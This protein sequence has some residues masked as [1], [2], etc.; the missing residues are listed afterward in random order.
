MAVVEVLGPPF[1]NYV[2]SVRM[3][4]EEKGVAYQL[5]EVFP[6]TP[7]ID[8]IHPLGKIPCLKHGEFGICESAAIAAYIDGAFPGPKLFPEEPKAAAIC[9]QWVSI[10]NTTIIPACQTYLAAYYFPRTEDGEPNKDVVVA[11]FP[12]ALE[13]L[14]LLDRVVGVTG[15]LAGDKFTYAD[16]DILPVIYYLSTLP[17]TGE[18]MKAL[19]ALSAY[20]GTHAKRAS[21][22]ATQPPSFAEF[23]ARMKARL[24]AQA[25]AA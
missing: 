14:Q 20:L 23:R 8:A 11:A 2:R 5:V 12:K 4:L 25:A 13:Y 3:A 1:S 17:E 9:A 6:H 7:Q 10:L 21:F 22:I 16:I 19:P 24:A 15:Y 18:A